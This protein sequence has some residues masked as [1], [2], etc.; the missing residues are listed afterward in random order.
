MRHLSIDI[1]TYSSADLPNCGLYKYVQSADFKIL[2]FAYS[3]D[4]G[5]VHLVDLEHERMPDEL[6]RALSDNTVI[7]HAFNAQFEWACLN[8]FWPSPIDQWQCSMVQ[9]MY[10]GFAGGLGAVS[11]ALNLPID[12]QK[13]TTGSA[14]IRLFS[15]P[16]NISN[17]R[18]LPGIN[19]PK[20]EQFK[21]YCKQD[22]VAEMA[23]ANKLAKFPLPANEQKLWELDILINSTGVKIDPELVSG[24]IYCSDTV[25]EELTKEAIELTGLNNPNSVKQLKAWLEKEIEED[26]PDLAKAT[27]KTLISDLSNEVVER[28]L[29]IRQELSKTSVKK[30]TAMYNA[31]GLDQ[32]VRGMLQFYGASRTGRWAGRLVQLH[33][34]PQNHISTLDYARKYVKNRNID[35]LKILYGNVPDT[36]SQLIRTAFIPEDLN[37]FLVADFS[38]IEARIIAWLAKEQ[39]RLD[40]FNTHGKIYEASASTMFNVPIEL[41][42]KGNPEYDLRAKGKVAEL[43]LGYGGAEGALKAMGALK[44]GISEG[45][46]KPLVDK[47]RTANPNILALWRAF[48]NAAKKAV[49]KCEPTTINGVTFGREMD[50]ANGLDFLTITLPSG[51]KLYYDKPFLAPSIYDNKALHYNNGK[52]GIDNTFGGKLTENVV[53]AIARDCL[54]ENLMRLNALGHKI[55]MHVHDEV[56]IEGDPKDLESICNVMGQPIAWAPELTLK[57]AGFSCNYYMKD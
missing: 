23:V 30:Y 28:V 45:E 16:N 54:A 10:C 13:S 26:V 8:K 7:K 18:T 43:A 52:L 5:E 33:N 32:R 3:W 46:L 4:Y 55:V 21:E 56:V 11:K 49:E 40:V 39:W 35:A 22:V 9:A 53:Q 38:S 12:K 57:A 44:M 47:W 25:T 14:L 15:L 37:K 34:L 31:T 48:E 19:M 50:T 2:L 17:T 29:R 27:V 6:I 1:E 42:K 51:R 20:W 41:I 36:L 24:A